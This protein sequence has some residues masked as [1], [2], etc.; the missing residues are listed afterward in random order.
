MRGIS[1][2]DGHVE[3]LIERVVPSSSGLRRPN[4]QA[5]VEPGEPVAHR[6]DDGGS[7]RGQ[8]ER[9]RTA[10]HPDSGWTIEGDLASFFASDTIEPGKFELR[11]TRTSAMNV[12]GFPRRENQERRTK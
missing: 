8:H 1:W 7:V 2:T 11:K 3:G 4:V 10:T 9:T 5:P 12:L 6:G